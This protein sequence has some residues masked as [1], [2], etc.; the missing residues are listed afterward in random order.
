[1]LFALYVLCTICPV[2]CFRQ[3][4]FEVLHD[5][6]LATLLR[7]TRTNIGT[8]TA[9]QTVK[10]VYLHTESHAFECLT[11]SFQLSE[12][13]TLLLFGIQYER[14]DSSVRTNIGTLVTLDTVFRIPFGNEC[15]NTTLFVFCGSLMPSTVFDT[16][17]CRYRQQVAVLCID[18]TNYFVDECRVVVFS[19]SI[20]C[21]VS[22][23][24]INGQLLVFATTVNG[25]IVLVD[26]VFTLLAIRLN[27]EFLHLLYSQVNRN[28]ACD[29]EECRLQDG[30]GAVAQT[31]FLCNLSCV[32]IVNSD[33]VLCKVLLYLVRQ[34]LSQFFA[35]P[36]RVQQERTVLTQTAGNVVHVQ[37]S[38]N[39]ASY[40]VRRIY[41]VSRTDRSI[42]E[43]Q[44]R[45]SETA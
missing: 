38:L 37:I 20:V 15:G 34:V 45:A 31:D 25:S 30:V 28:Y 24:R 6:R 8:V 29:T 23:S 11:Y 9:T 13:G 7:I 39:M 44:V 16:L 33:I 19:L 41:Q 42:A 5:Q 43:T 22:P 14:T 36:D 17:E 27:D 26:N 40:E 21:Q 10:N 1:M 4:A 35:F 2:G 3:L 12:V 32:D 18:R